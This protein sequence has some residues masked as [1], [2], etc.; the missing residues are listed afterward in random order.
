MPDITEDGLGV[1][2]AILAQSIREID[3]DDDAQL[4]GMPNRVKRLDYLVGQ[5]TM[6]ATDLASFS[7]GS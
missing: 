2:L 4:S 3:R 5:A 6:G 7:G 1:F